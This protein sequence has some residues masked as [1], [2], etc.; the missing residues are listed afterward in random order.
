M[1]ENECSH[2]PMPE[3]FD[4]HVDKPA[5]VSNTCLVTVARNRYLIPCELAGQVVSTRLYPSAVVVVAGDGAVTRHE[6]LSAE[7]QTRYDWQHYILLWCRKPS[8]LRNGA[9]FVDLPEALDSSR[10]HALNSRT[11]LSGQSRATT[12]DVTAI[13]TR[14][15]AD[16]LLGAI[17][18]AT[19]PAAGAAMGIPA[20]RDR[21]DSTNRM[22]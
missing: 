21:W 1:L 9:P 18:A 20:D 19:N 8:A 13:S 4:D 14:A 2:L 11:W 6:R 16:A 17:F 5:R 12:A 7:G 15:V 10:N 3:S 22:D